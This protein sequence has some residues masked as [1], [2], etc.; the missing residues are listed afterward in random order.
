M[1][2]RGTSAKVNFDKFR[3]LAISWNVGIQKYL[4]FTI[5]IKLLI[6][7]WY[8]FYEDTFGLQFR[9]GAAVDGHLGYSCCL[10]DPYLQSTAS[11]APTVNDNHNLYWH[12]CQLLLIAVHYLYLLFQIGFVP[13]SKLRFSYVSSV[14][15]S[16]QHN[17]KDLQN[18]HMN[19]FNYSVVISFYKSFSI[20]DI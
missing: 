11:K 17:P 16:S 6:L 9:R 13:E 12:I 1:H 15:H 3:S 7:S 18:S 4:L 14:T 10:G 19:D 5:P 20:Y 2:C 8:A